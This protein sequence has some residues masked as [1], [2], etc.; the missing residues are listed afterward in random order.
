[1]KVITQVKTFVNEDSANEFMST[2][3]STFDIIDVRYESCGY[4]EIFMVL[5]YKR[6]ND[7]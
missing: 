3:E 5:Y 7:E 1:M 4:K 6:V 2:F